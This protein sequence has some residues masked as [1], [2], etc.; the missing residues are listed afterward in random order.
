MRISYSVIPSKSLPFQ[1]WP[2]L[3]GGDVALEDFLFASQTVKKR[4]LIGDIE[5]CFEDFTFDFL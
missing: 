3:R 5:F 1:I 4:A 2:T